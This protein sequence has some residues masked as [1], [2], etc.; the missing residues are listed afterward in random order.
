M[1]SGTRAGISRASLGQMMA[2]VKREPKSPVP[3]S[4]QGTPET[5]VPV[6]ARKHARQRTESCNSKQM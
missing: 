5:L 4:R 6:R 3:R 1:A 2:G